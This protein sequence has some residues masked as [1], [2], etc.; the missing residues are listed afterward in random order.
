MP[1]PAASANPFGHTITSEDILDT[2]GFLDSWEDRYK[3]IIDLGKEL[4][5]MPAA[6]HTGTGWCTA[7]RAR[8][9]SIPGWKM[10][11]CNWR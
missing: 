1:D 4:P 2:L 6:L 11:A 10:G 9:G 3:Y 5:A 8:S 7:A